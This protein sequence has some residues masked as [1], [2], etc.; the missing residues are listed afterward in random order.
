[1]V[2]ASGSV[3]CHAALAPHHLLNSVMHRGDECLCRGVSSGHNQKL[4][5]K[6]EEA[7]ARMLLLPQSFLS[8]G[9]HILLWV[10]VWGVRRPIAQHFQA[11]LSLEADAPTLVADDIFLT[12]QTAP[13]A[14]VFMLR[15]HPWASVFRNVGVEGHPFSQ[16][17]HPLTRN[18]ISRGHQT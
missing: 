9:P 6:L 4:L 2:H 17:G 15:G 13:G 10:Q 1:M 18:S 7:V 3:L 5:R 8:P 11:E 14:S 12:N 16:N